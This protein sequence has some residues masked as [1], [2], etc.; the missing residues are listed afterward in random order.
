MAIRSQKPRNSLAGSLTP[1]QRPQSRFK[2]H[3]LKVSNEDIREVA[4][5]LPEGRVYAN[6]RSF[7]PFARQDLYGKLLALAGLPQAAA[8]ASTPTQAQAK[9]PQQKSELRS[10][11][12][13]HWDAIAVGN[14]V[15]ANEGLEMDDGG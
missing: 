11:L 10:L 12:P 14:I 8:T 2:Y 1:R 15:V 4:R 7:I 5:K 6:G 9:A 13:A 3:S